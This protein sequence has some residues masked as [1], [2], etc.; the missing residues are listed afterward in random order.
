MT[1]QSDD[2]AD[3][4]PGAAELEEK[5][6]IDVPRL[7]FRP[8]DRA[9]VLREAVDR[10]RQVP[11]THVLTELRRMADE[12]LQDEA[13]PPYDSWLVELQTNDG[14][15]AVAYPAHDYDKARDRLTRQRTEHPDQQWRLVRETDTF[16]VVDPEPAVETQQPET[17]PEKE[18][19][20]E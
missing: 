2:R 16:T 9:A 20:H 10:L 1:D 14:H 13:H 18:T 11:F 4:L 12:A 15:W 3:A 6:D 8:A 7:H 17:D 5:L 19:G